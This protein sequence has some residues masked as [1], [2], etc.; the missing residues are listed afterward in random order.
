L[1]VSSCV[2][3]RGVESL[4]MGGGGTRVVLFFEH[5]HIFFSFFFKG[6]GG[7]FFPTQ[8]FY[9]SNF[10]VL[11]WGAL[12]WVVCFSHPTRGPKTPLFFSSPPSLREGGG[13]RAFGFS[14]PGRGSGSTSFPGVFLVGETTPVLG[15]RSRTS[16]FQPVPL[17]IWRTA[18][19][20]S[21]FIFDFPLGFLSACSVEP[22]PVPLSAG[23]PKR[24]FLTKTTPVKNVL[25]C[26]S[27]FVV[28]Q[29]NP[30]HSSVTRT[31]LL[32]RR[33]LCP[34]PSGCY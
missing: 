31:A 12:F 1:F 15:V 33:I 19:N 29:I 25:K 21:S 24:P 30:N 3:P 14:D 9:Q 26:P 28:E 7:F 23:F 13:S 22:P 4:F 27:T 10:S 32:P 17:S 6:G 18:D 5:P 11:F 16:F 34:P 2:H 8:T 20:V